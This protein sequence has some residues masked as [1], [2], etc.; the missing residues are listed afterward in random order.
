MPVLSVD[1]KKKSNFAPQKGKMPEWPIGTVSKTVV[2]VTVPR[3][4]IPLFPQAKS[5]SRLRLFFVY[6]RRRAE[7]A[8]EIRHAAAWAELVIIL[9]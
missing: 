5:R 6:T 4:R 1:C 7:V 2:R 9:R 3:V 8:N